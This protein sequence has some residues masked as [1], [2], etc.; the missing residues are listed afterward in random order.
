MEQKQYLALEVEK[1]EKTFRFLM[2]AGATWGAAIDAAH[3]ILME[4]NKLSTQSAEL[5]KPEKGD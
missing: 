3:S 5:A 4:V 1:N 2:P